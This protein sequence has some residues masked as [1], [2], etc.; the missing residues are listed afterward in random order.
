MINVFGLAISITFSFLLWLYINDQLSYDVHQSNAAQVYRVNA[1]FNM[2][3]KR[4][5]YSNAPRPIGPNLQ[6]DYPEVASQLRMRGLGGLSAH[7]ATLEY[8][9]KKV[10]SRKIFIADSTYFD[11]FDQTFLM[12]SP[13]HALTEA[14]SIV[15]T[16]SFAKKLFGDENPMGKTIQYV[17]YR[18]RSLKITG[19][20]TDDDRNTHL[21]VEAL[22]S[23]VTFPYEREM[24]QWYGA[25][26]YTYIRLQEGVPITG[27]ESKI[28]QFVDT[29][30]KETFDQ[31]NGTANLIFQNIRDI[32]LAAPYVW[33]PYPQGS[34]I[35]VIVLK[36]VMAFLLV[37]ACINYVNM[38]TANSAERAAEVGIRKTLGSSRKL[39][40][41]QFLAES[42]LISVLSAC[43]ALLLSFSL[44]EMFNDLAD[45]RFQWSDLTTSTNLGAL[46]VVSVTIGAL[47]GTY[48]AFYLSSI[49]IL[50]TLKGRFV[51]SKDGVFLRKVLVTIQ[52]TIAAVLITGIFLVVK[53]IQHIK[54]KDIGYDKE[55]ILVLDLPNDSLVVA[56]SHAFSKE[57]KNQS[58]IIGTASSYYRLDEEANQFTPTLRNPDGSTF[59]KGADL[60]QVDHD[61]IETIGIK[62]TAGRNF[63][64]SSEYDEDKSII[65]N[66][67][68]L[69]SFGWTESPLGGA[70]KSGTDDDGNPKFMNVV[71]VV[72]DFNLGVSY[73]EVNPLI[74]FYDSRSSGSLF[75]RVTPDNL[76]DHVKGIEGLWDEFFP[77]HKLSYHFVDQD[78]EKLY[79][80]EDKFLSL[81]SVFSIVI[82]VI[83]SLGLLGL[84]SYL[85]EIKRKEIAI[86][87]VLGSPVRAI[88]L[89]LS[90]RFL[91]L[92]MLA[93]LISLPIT[94]QLINLW[95]ENFSSRVAISIWPFVVSLLT[96]IGFTVLALSY[97]VKK[98]SSENPVYALKHE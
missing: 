84:V 57:L 49:D 60:I 86:R 59:R 9:E 78:L 61:F 93:N 80:R 27:I 22:V 47:A 5:I 58:N 39:L 7:T 14:N 51:T 75:V 46:L 62:L 2:N 94:Y 38:A 83:A 26:V 98:A 68:A 17:S 70:L 4:D 82:I 42:V 16:Q 53:Q 23:W 89:L 8:K 52:Y 87:K 76:F 25:H 92:L 21:P 73:A 37:F 65:I 19:V 1:D 97:H 50:K 96:A 28:P 3:G 79:R 54:T 11:V 77:D 35:N 6:R 44:L 55:N 85:T 43:L 12:G 48:P 41:G 63:N 91:W 18:P 32:H 95:M 13:E 67:A 20:M 66:E 24:T 72:K 40:V 33:E 45:V 69:K 71:G 56:K 90:R 81:L 74:I 34:E 15:I 10:E 31:M 64:P 88:V 36:F 30:M 29:H